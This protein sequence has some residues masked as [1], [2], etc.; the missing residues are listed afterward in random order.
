MG[1]LREKMRHAL[2]VRGMAANTQ[3][4]YLDSVRALAKYYGR[5]P[6]ELST[7]EIQRYVRYLIE[8]RKLA[9]ASTPVETTARR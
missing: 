1:E 7:E 4:A 8:E 2:V 3:A 6:D 5:R 9:P